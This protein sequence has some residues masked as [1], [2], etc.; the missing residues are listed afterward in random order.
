LCN[1][2]EQLQICTNYSFLPKN[3]GF[4]SRKTSAHAARV[5]CAGT[6]YTPFRTPAARYRFLQTKIST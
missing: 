4:F 6:F 2:E 5:M 3:Q 1:F